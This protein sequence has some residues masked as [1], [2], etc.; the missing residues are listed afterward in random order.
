MAFS[1]EEAKYSVLGARSALGHFPP[2]G[3]KY[4]VLRSQ[5]ELGPNYDGCALNR[6]TPPDIAEVEI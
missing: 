5:N 3:V 1:F 2:T 6:F 4:N